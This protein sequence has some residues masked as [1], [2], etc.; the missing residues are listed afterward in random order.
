MVN[1][2]E[3]VV[4]ITRIVPL[5]QKDSYRRAAHA[6]G[7]DGTYRTIKNPGNRAT[8]MSGQRTVLDSDTIQV[9]VFLASMHKR[10]R[11][12]T[13]LVKQKQST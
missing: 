7:V 8:H 3:A 13:E 4:N 9:R 10:E 2:S 12:E 6:K 1:K 5:E 11:F